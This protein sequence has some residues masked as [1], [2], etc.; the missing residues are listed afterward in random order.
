MHIALVL[1]KA[2]RLELRSLHNS[3]RRSLI[4]V[5]VVGRQIFEAVLVDDLWVVRCLI[6]E[7]LRTEE[8]VLVEGNLGVHYMKG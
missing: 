8:M 1:L 4:V 2:F 7:A 5:R 6:Q 3:L